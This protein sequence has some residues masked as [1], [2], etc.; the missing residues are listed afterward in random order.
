[1]ANS[2]TSRT[3]AKLRK[4]GWTCQ[5]VEKYNTFIK[6]RIDL[7]NFIDIVAIKGNE[8]MGVQTTSDRTG[9]NSGERV[10]KIQAN[11]YYLKV[12][13]AGWKIIVHAWKSKKVGKRKLWN[14]KVIEL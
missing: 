1:M 3:L 5:I 4:E 8:T 12:K 9:G 13:E 10:R 2:P 14:C 7:F 11:E 6:R